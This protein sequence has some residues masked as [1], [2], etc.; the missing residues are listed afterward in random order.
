[1]STPSSQNW[2]TIIGIGQDGYAPLNQ[3]AKTALKSA[4]LILGSKRQLGL[5]P[6]EQTKSAKREAWPSPMLP[7]LE[8][9]K[10]QRPNKTVIIATGDPMCWGIGEHFSNT[11]KTNQMRIIPA[12]SIITLICA[13]MH[14][15]SAVTQSLSLC[16][17]PLEAMA[18]YL[19]SGKNLILLSATS[20]HPNKVANLLKTHGYGPS[21]LTIL[22]NIGAKNETITQTSIND[23]NDKP[24]K[25]AALNSLALSLEKEP[26]TPRLTSNPGL[27]DQAFEHDG[28]LTK[29]LI[30]AI[31]LAHLRPCSGE[32]LWDIGCGNGS[33][34]IE[35]LRAASN[36]NAIG[37]EKNN[38][39][40]KTCKHNADHLGVPHL[41]IIKGEAPTCFQTKKLKQT[42]IETANN[43]N[44]I[45][46]GG[47]ITTPNLLD[48]A[49]KALKP[50]GRLVA[51]TVTIEG[52]AVLIKAYQTHGGALARHSHQ[53]ADPIGNQDGN[54]RL[55]FHGWR[56]QMPIVQW[57]YHKS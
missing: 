42:E 47:G 36:T 4:Q 51:N 37:F 3:E 49:L 32:L 13:K 16:S 5:I 29:Q 45:F 7:R 56:P 15:P 2:L 24:R 40:A 19:E 33:I 34:A 25:F 43:P 14:W 35:W 17:Q 6:T 28:Q 23:L 10:K 31:T 57:V 48:K 41:Q 30:R 44:A 8:S 22:E 52:E 21:K 39:R 27:P 11:R 18:R 46:I 38:K 50:G 53:Q 9:L 26:Q 55:N 54:L 12:P 1:M 20:D